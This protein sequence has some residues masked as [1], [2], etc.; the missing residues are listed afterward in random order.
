MAPK[1]EFAF[2]LRIGATEDNYVP[3]GS[4][5]GALQRF[6]ANLNLGGIEGPGLKAQIGPGSSEWFHLDPETGLGQQSTRAVM[7]TEEGDHICVTITGLLVVD[8]QL[9]E[10]VKW[11]PNK[12][13][14]RPEDHHWIITPTFETNSEKLKWLERNHFIGQGH[15][16]LA[17]VGNGQIGEYEVYKVVPV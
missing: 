11:S 5:K 8:D 1:L 15:V 12:K 2:T 7:K 17:E 9:M 14:T 4:V 6:I 13:N 10:S 3:L 16:V